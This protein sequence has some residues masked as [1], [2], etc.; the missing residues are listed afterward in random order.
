MEKLGQIW[1]LL[2]VGVKSGHNTSGS[3]ERRGFVVCFELETGWDC[4]GRFLLM[5]KL[6]LE[7]RANVRM[8]KE[9]RESSDALLERILVDLN[10]DHLFCSILSYLL[11]R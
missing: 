3:A 11:L 4:V 8:D 2:A 7:G 10:D 9:P 6:L 1:A 5:R